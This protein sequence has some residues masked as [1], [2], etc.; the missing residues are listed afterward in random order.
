MFQLSRHEDLEELNKHIL[1]EIRHYC[2]DAPKLHVGCQLDH[3]NPPKSRRHQSV[4]PLAIQYDVI[5]NKA[6]EIRA[7]GYVECS[8]KTRVGVAEVFEAIFQITVVIKTQP[9]PGGVKPSMPFFEILPDASSRPKKATALMPYEQWIHLH[10][11]PWALNDWT[12]ARVDSTKRPN[13]LVSEVDK[14][15]I[16]RPNDVIDGDS[17]RPMNAAPREEL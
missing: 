5:I 1:P 14:G 13:N 10:A 12:A 8:A 15:T 6:V 3:R 16:P 2:P 17:S 9:Q 4:G 7:W 11:L